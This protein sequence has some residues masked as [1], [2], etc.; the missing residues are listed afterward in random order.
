M[1][2]PTEHLCDMTSYYSVFRE[3]TNMKSTLWVILTAAV[4]SE[5][6]A[7]AVCEPNRCK[8]LGGHYGGG[9]RT[10]SQ[11]HRNHSINPMIQKFL[12]MKHDFY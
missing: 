9:H 5:A 10:E 6:A 1:Y 2:L 3:R 11:P 8:T 7:Q 4:A 12:N